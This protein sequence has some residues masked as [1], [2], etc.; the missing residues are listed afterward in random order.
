MTTNLESVHTIVVPA[1][2]Y[3]A[4]AAASQL[5]AG[6]YPDGFP[7]RCDPH[8]AGAVA[9]L[10]ARYEGGQVLLALSDGRPRG[11]IGLRRTGT[12]A[13]IDGLTVLPGAQRRRLLDRLVG[14]ALWEVASEGIETIE[15]EVSPFDS[16]AV[17]VLAGHGFVD[18]SAATSG[19]ELIARRMVRIGELA[20]IA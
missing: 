15:V 11:V 4:A 9:A 8:H 12:G 10:R 16:T 20:A 5:M 1:T 3:G 18:V 6:G 7:G 2:S 17:A 13:T 14:E 19:G